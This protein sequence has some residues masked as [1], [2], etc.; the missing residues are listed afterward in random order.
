MGNGF[1]NMQKTILYIFIVYML[2]THASLALAKNTEELTGL[3]K[4]EKSINVGDVQLTARM[5]SQRPK[6]KDI[7]IIDDMSEENQTLPDYKEDDV[8]SIGK[9]KKHIIGEEDTLIDV[10]RHFKLGYIE[11]ISA[12]PNV[13]PWIPTPGQEIT[14]PEFK[15][16]P[17]ARQK[18]IVVNLAQM[19]LYYFK[20]K[21]EIITYP[22]G[23][24]RDGLNT[25]QGKTY[26]SAKKA[27]PI[28]IPTKRMREEKKWLPK[29]I[30][31]GNHNP[32][33]K[34]ALYLGWPT[35]LIHG[36]NKP[37]AIGRRVSSGCM[38]MYPE[39]VKE[40]FDMVPLNIPI[41][42][43]SQPILLAEID[44]ELYLEAN[45]SKKQGH[46]I[47]LTGTHEEIDLS[48]EL[49]KVITD[50]AGDKV[51][52]IDWERVNQVIRTRQSYPISI[53]KNATDEI[54]EEKKKPVRGKRNE[55]VYN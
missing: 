24:G 36:S 6:L 18:G 40:L 35:F 30:S 11:L 20:S 41:T 50:A 49:K 51:D 16:L 4:E 3:S 34:H 26:L 29:A 13:D 23:I 47:E 17:R 43:V 15:I 5:P 19:R 25:P 1:L 37:W 28:W 54:V 27:N 38:R 55:F 44:G 31:A 53:S 22:I 2:V 33:G 9:N 45:P 42:I 8:R 14:I 52:T 32:L 12:N 39:N 48:D 46:D 7:S 21:N 10:S